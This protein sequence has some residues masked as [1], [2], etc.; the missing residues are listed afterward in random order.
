MFHLSFGAGRPETRNEAIPFQ[1]PSS[2][3]LRVNLERLNPAS[4]RML[5]PKLGERLSLEPLRDLVV[6]LRH[7]SEGLLRDPTGL[8][9]SGMRA[10]R[11]QTAG[12]RGLSVG[13]ER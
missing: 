6:R 12:L 2:R 9:S 1:T 3:K 5:V 11:D 4:S 8:G 10:G 13:E 7:H